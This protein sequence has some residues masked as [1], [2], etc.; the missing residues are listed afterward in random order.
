MKCVVS[1]CRSCVPATSAEFGEVPS[2]LSLRFRVDVN[3]VKYD[4]SLLFLAI[5]KD[6]WW[7]QQ[8]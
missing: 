7:P 5:P 3:L 2:P 1:W 8:G 4:P 6:G